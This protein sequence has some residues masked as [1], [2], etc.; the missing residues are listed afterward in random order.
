[1]LILLFL[2][3]TSHGCSFENAVCGCGGGVGVCVGGGRGGG[4][5][6]VGVGLGGGG[7]PKLQYNINK[8]LRI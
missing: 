4:K 6:M 2:R 5:T 3:I 8:K 1:M 7:V